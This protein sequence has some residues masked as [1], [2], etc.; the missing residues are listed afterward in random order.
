MSFPL[1]GG[2][3]P[4]GRPEGDREP[5]RELV[6][7]LQQ[8]CRPVDQAVG[9]G[10]HGLEGDEGATGG[11]ASEPP[12]AEPI[13]RRT[14]DDLYA[15]DGDRRLAVVA[16]DGTSITVDSGPGY[17]FG[18]VWVPAGRPFVALEPMTAATNSLVDGTAPLLQPGDEFT[19]RFT[20]TLGAPRGT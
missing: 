13:G 15:L 12:E 8:R 3:R 16:G 7:G 4:L 14:F 5:G 17:P 6:A 1:V 10:G 18:Q 2:S 19:A 20:I 11:S 9:G